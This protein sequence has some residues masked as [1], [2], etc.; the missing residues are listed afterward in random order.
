MTALT[1]GA[2]IAACG[3]GSAGQDREPADV[4]VEHDAPDTDI[5]D[6][7][8]I[9]TDQDSPEPDMGDGVLPDEVEVLVTLDGE[10]VPSTRVVQ[11]GTTLTW[12][13]GADGRVV[14]QPDLEVMGEIVLLGSH[15]EARIRGV[16]VL[17]G[18]EQ[19]LVIDL[20]R[21]NTS[22]N[23][24]YTFQDP[25]EPSRRNTTTQC[26]H[27]HQTINDAWYASPHRT[28]ASNPVVHDLY[29][30]VASGFDSEEDCTRAGGRWLQGVAPGGAGIAFRC[31]LGQGVLPT[32]NT[33][34]EEAPCEGN[35]A[36]DTFGA[37]ADCHAPAINKVLGG[38]DLMEATEFAYDYG[39]SCNLCHQV[40]RIDM[41]ALPGV[42]GRL[43][44]TRP[45][46]R[47]SVTLGAGGNLPLTFGPSHDSPNPR[48]GSV[49]RDHFRDGTLCAG[50]HQQEQAVLIPGVDIDRDRWPSE[51]LPVHTTFEE[52]KQGA[53]A[54]A[55][56]CPS[57]HM[58]PD[59]T[60]SNGADLQRFENA[61][62]GI[63]GGWLRP[64][65][66]VRRHSWLGP[67]Q[68][69]GAMLEL[70]AAVFIE[71]DPVLDG[72]LTARVTVQNVSA[73]HAIPTGEPMR[74]ILLKVE[75]RCDDTALDAVG[76]D[77]VPSWGGH[78]DRRTT[79]QT[80]NTWPGAEVGDA[81]RVVRRTGDFH[82]YQGFGSFGDGTFSA[83]QKG[84]SVE[85]V[86]G[87][88]VIT[89]VDEDGE[90]VFDRP[91]PGGDVAYRTRPGASHDAMAGAPGFGFARVMVGVDGEQMVPH[92]AAV[93]VVSDN[94][95]MPQQAWTSTH[96]FEA[97]CDAPE[98]QAT[99][100]YRPYPL[101]LAQERG[102]R[103]EDTIMAEARR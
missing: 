72:H 16:D 50:C 9:S 88:A 22:D 35:P 65:G 97:T 82:D 25:G 29:S 60:V 94:R 7:S 54:E 84:M 89:A 77:A 24:N 6:P 12:K 27:C 87:F 75:A 11:G 32:L 69:E 40:D 78:L 71:H 93:D 5:G 53:L 100:L 90:V 41:D 28:S 26:G 8:D 33:A 42:A 37:C 66:Q 85:V 98:V 51:K 38:R 10:P 91:L 20:I 96:I 56:R 63:Q 46:E 79:A 15:P 92:F 17:P 49:Q 76:G 2:L 45:S 21:Y 36:V 43:V 14:V 1:A 47:G 59:P 58:P 30:G 70:A 95:L 102:W 81:V 103:F 55:T 61:E 101:G 73:G 48:M 34:C 68:P 83:A 3:G 80:W 57:C 44:I 39:V 64:P 74:H 13:T 52:W 31:Y 18:I 4:Q 23:P 62:V 99:L 67:R 19:P 86:A